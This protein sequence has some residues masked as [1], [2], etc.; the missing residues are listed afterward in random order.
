V[1]VVWD[2]GRTTSVAT[3]MPASKTFDN[4]IK[5]QS[6]RSDV[7]STTGMVACSQPFAA[8][9]GVDIL[10]SGG[11]A[12]DAAIA[13]AAALNVTEPCSTGLGGDCF[14]LYYDS[15][16]K[17]VHAMNG[18]GR[19]PAALTL[20]RV[21][22]DCVPEGKFESAP[23]DADGNVTLS[24]LCQFHAHTVTVPGTAAG[25]CDAVEKWGSGQKTMADVLR[26][27]IELARRGFPV[28]PI[29]A[30]WWKNGVAQ[31]RNGPNAAE[32]LMPKTEEAP[33]AGEVFRNPHLADV[34]ELIA[35]EGKD[36]FYKGAPGQAIV[37]VLRNLG[38]VMT[39]DDLAGH[40]TEFPDPISTSYGGV[41]LVE[42]PPNGQGII[43]L[44][45]TNYLKAALETLGL[46]STVSFAHNSAEYLHL[47]IESLRLAFADGK[48]FVSDPTTAKVKVSELLSPAYAKQRVASCFDKSKANP[49]VKAGSPLNACD[50][51][52]F[53]VVDSTGS[54]VSMVNSN[55]MGFGSGIIPRGCGFS[56]QNRGANFSVVPGHANAVAGAKRP[57]HTILPALL[58]ESAS[59]QLVASFTVMGGFMQPQGH[60][61]VLLNTR[62]HGMSPQVCAQIILC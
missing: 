3:T 54:A 61:Q 43:A 53:Q 32:L 21:M 59:R 20:E 48:M 46:E 62:D 1:W 10:R 42:C 52:S 30:H 44:L 22:K 39:A 16:T 31:L 9:A 14:L 25:W 49:D 13:V 8:Q 28:S 40:V 60:L 29:T 45:A 26:P 33:R 35:K 6:R 38:G 56:L 55:Y 11:N 15:K 7:F 19:S 36:G 18:S 58:V 47:V 50:T 34:M 37:E 17:Q 41:D 4:D 5:F 51:V 2:E 57:Y 23:R 27:A 12:V 24:D